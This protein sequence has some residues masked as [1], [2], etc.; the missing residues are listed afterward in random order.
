MQTANNTADY[1]I[2][3]PSLF[4]LNLICKITNVDQ[5]IDSCITKGCHEN[6]GYI[7]TELDF[8]VYVDAMAYNCF[9]DIVI[10]IRHGLGEDREAQRALLTLYNKL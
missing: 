2:A 5:H 9:E 8:C 4:K 6:I 7:N 1:M 3:N 10:V